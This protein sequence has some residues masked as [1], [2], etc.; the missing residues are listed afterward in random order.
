M[1]CC[2]QSLMAVKAALL[3]ILIMFSVYYI[4]QSKQSLYL[5]KYYSWFVLYLF[6][7]VAALSYGILN[8]NPGTRYYY[9]IYLVWPVVF[10]I[11][12]TVL[13]ETNI[14]HIIKLFEVSYTVILITGIMTFL[15]WNFGLFSF[16]NQE[17]FGYEFD[18]LARP[19]F[20]LIS[21]SGPA[22]VE[23]F[24]LFGFL[25]AY[26]CID[27]NGIT[28]RRWMLLFT[29]MLY[30][31]LSSRRIMIMGFIFIPIIY[32]ALYSLMKF[33]SKPKVVA[34]KPKVVANT[35]RLYIFPIIAMVFGMGYI[36]LDSDDAMLFFT[37]A[38]SSDGDLGSSENLRLDQYT[39]LI[40]GWHDNFLLGAGT[41][42][43][44]KVS[45]SNIPGTYELSYIAI[46]FE[47]GTLGGFFYFSLLAYPIIQAI[48]L[49]K[50]SNEL[51]TKQLLISYS[52]C[53]IAMLIANA[54]NPYLSA[55][56]FMWIIF[57]FIVILNLTEKKLV[58]ERKNLCNN[59]G[60]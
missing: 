29:G 45:R 27:S 1:L 13:K 50:Q 17:L 37:S 11:I 10:P 41:G 31:V 34:N 9:L 25:L 24:A 38:F 56:D 51:Q 28:F 6:S 3:A 60:I 8:G 53:Y 59:S 43:D 23:F 46:L 39:A 21:H 57:L 32:I 2:S 44:A 18:E 47:R 14:K 33:H 36:F 16:F 26:Y 55:F 12:F 54:T 40:N 30:I 20:L 5:H 48:R 22:L 19:M 4:V 42:I 49:G 15:K 7:N 58:Y 35:V 52:T